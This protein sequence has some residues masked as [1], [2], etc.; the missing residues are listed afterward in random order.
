V[1]KLNN[2]RKHIASFFCWKNY[3][4]S[5][6]VCTFV[7]PIAAQ[8][9]SD[10]LKQEKENIEKAINSRK[11]LLDQNK[12]NTKATFQQLQLLESQLASRNALID[13]VD[14]QIRVAELKINERSKEIDKLTIRQQRLKEK[15]KKLLLYAYKHRSKYGSWMYVFSSTSFFEAK[16]RIAY[17][18]KLHHLQQTQFQLIKQN[19]KLIKTEITGIKTSKSENE[20][21]AVTKIAEK[22]E[23]EGDQKIAELLK[24]DEGK[25]ANLK[26]Q[27]KRAIEKE[28]AAEMLAEKKKEEA[29]KKSKK[30]SKTSKDTKTTK[31]SKDTKDTPKEEKTE[32]VVSVKE[33]S[34]QGINFE[35]NRGQIPWP[36]E[37]GSITEGYGKHAHPTLAN[38]YT[39]NNGID[40]S[41]PKGANVR[42]VLEGEVT[43]IFEIPGAGKVVIIKHGNYRTVYSNLQSVSVSKGQK[44]KT[45]QSIGV[46][47]IDDG[48]S[49][50]HFEIHK[51]VGADV[52]KLNPSLWVAQ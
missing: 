19:K 12:A 48:V 17:L 31:D 33:A 47:L 13:N 41:T 49:V 2:Y 11:S 27:I 50:V 23:I 10:K 37:S 43:T 34:P 14:N 5:V 9:Q 46:L 7:L 6:V 21:L 35:N 36:V 26:Q 52:I 20:Q 16:R 22:V 24:I 4:L 51:V 40:I 39:N 45:K 29:D 18:K 25:K 15:F 1:L 8:K 3:F 44:V 30:S 38:V 28:L 42:C 32:K